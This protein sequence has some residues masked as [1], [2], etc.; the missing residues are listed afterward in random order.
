VAAEGEKH[1]FDSAAE[2]F[3][4]ARTEEELRAGLELEQARSAALERDLETLRS[5]E[6]FRIGHA[7]VEGVHARLRWNV[8]GMIH[9]VGQR[10]RGLPPAREADARRPTGGARWR[11][12]SMTMFVAWGVDE[13]RL[14]DYASRVERLQAVLVELRPFFVV[15]SIVVEPVRR[16]GYP[17]EYLVPL[18]EWR[19]HRPAHEW[20]PYVTERMAEVQRRHQPGAVVILEGPSATSALDQGLLNPI[21]LPSI[22]AGED[23]QL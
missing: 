16:R 6:A 23:N 8:L 19:E 2:Q 22:G 12:G 4:I 17:I 1:D 13:S 20:G 5:S 9:A 15:D 3:A 21:L 18:T 10:L 11:D 7:L 14:E